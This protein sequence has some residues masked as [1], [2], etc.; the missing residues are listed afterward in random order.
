MLLANGVD[1]KTVQT[2]L[3]HADPAL[4]LKWYAHSVEESSRQAAALM[5]GLLA[6]S[7]QIV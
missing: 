4:T 3:G 5:G 1:V 7:D 6:S 2:R